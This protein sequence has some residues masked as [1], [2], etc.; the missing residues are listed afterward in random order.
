[1]TLPLQTFRYSA[2]YTFTAAGANPT[3][4]EVIAAVNTMLVAEVA[5]GSYW[6]VSAYSAGANNTLEIKRLGSPGGALGAVRGRIFGGTNAPNSAALG[7][8]VTAAAN[9]MYAGIAENAGIAQAG[10]DASYTAGAPYTTTTSKKWSGAGQAGNNTTLVASGGLRTFMFECDRFCAIFISDA[11]VTIPIFIGGF[12]ERLSDNTEIFA[13]AT[14][15][16]TPVTAATYATLASSTLWMIAG[17]DV[18]TISGNALIGWHDG[19]NQH[20]LVRMMVTGRTSDALLGVGRGTLVPIV[21]HDKLQTA[22]SDTSA[23]FG[24]LRQIRF[25]PFCNNK[26]S[27]ADSTPAITC[28]GVSGGKLLLRAGVYFDVNQ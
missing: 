4:S 3:V 26:I 24:I 13:C 21:V 20:M 11:S 22:A 10:P 23:E 27:V 1:M 17:N 12:V 25:G 16:V 9:V 8:G 19:S 14:A 28:Y 6:G 15:G 18:Q 5:N 2:D 7:N